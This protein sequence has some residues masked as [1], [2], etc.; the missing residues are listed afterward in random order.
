[1][2]SLPALGVV[3]VSYKSAD[4]LPACLQSLLHSAGVRLR[5]VV[6]DNGS[7]DQTPEAI[8]AWARASGVALD[9]TGTTPH[10]IEL[11]ETGQN[12]GFAAGVNVGLRV[13]MQ[14]PT[15]E[16]FWI[17]NPD[18]TVAPETAQAF[19][20][21]PSGFSLMGGRVVY[22]DRP[23]Q[24]QIDGGT[25]RWATGTTHNVNQFAPCTCA[26]PD[27]AGFDFITGASMVASR[28]FVRAAGYMPEE[29]FLYYEEVDW[30]MRRGRLPLA[31]AQGALVYHQAGSSI[32]SPAP[33]RPASLLS[34]YYK[35]HG[36]M[37]FLR[38]HRPLCLPS[39][40]VFS[41]GK[42]LQLA[43]QGQARAAMMVLGASL[44][45]ARAPKP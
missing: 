36:R 16:R 18:C 38:R 2:S 10:G 44:G 42:A 20:T 11:I 12:A 31:Y 6:V 21:A 30:A 43:L 8:R 45:L 17:L 23:D 5:I 3:I 35:N 40:F 7:P 27:P 25:I 26:A 32:G 9:G 14:D 41:V 13:L 39:A 1:M 22:A 29:Y 4:V 37:R 15:L 28:A 24:I 33:G 19:A 34:L